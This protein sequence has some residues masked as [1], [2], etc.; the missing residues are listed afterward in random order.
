VFENLASF[1][2]KVDGVSV[3]VWREGVSVAENLLY[4]RSFTQQTNIFKQRA[5]NSLERGTEQFI[6]T[7]EGTLDKFLGVDIQKV[8][9]DGFELS[10]PF[11]IDCLVSFVEDGCELDLNA[12]EPPTPVGKPLLH[13][14]ENGK[15]RKHTWNYGTAVGM[16]GYL[17]GST[18]PDISMA[19]HQCARFINDPKRSHERAMIRLVRYLKT[20]KDRGI[21]FKLK[22]ELGL[23]CFADADFA[24]GWT[25]ADGDNLEQVMSRT[26]YLLR[27]AGCPIGWCSKLQSE[28]AL[29][30]AE[31]EYIALPKHQA[32]REV[33]P[34]MELLREM[35]KY[36]SFL[37]TN[38]PH[39][40]C[41]VWEDNQSCI[42]MAE[43]NRFSP[44]AKHIALKYHHLGKISISYINTHEQLAD[45]L[46]KPLDD[47][48]FFVL[49]MMLNGY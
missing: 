1:A 34:L 10:Q 35:Q 38:T 44:R 18:R 14:D 40:K 39:F 45:I 13:K 20:T 41:K 23:E 30:T 33:I 11:L 2:E 24:G 16:S 43:S 29:S 37:Y 36:M 28:I 15:V 49:R 6:L 19:S 5:G 9:V 8:G 12:K 7:K 17:Q 22:P 42:T 31:A 4:C 25:Q 48:T 47:K 32:L 46:T 21:V 27:Y 26:G 3:S